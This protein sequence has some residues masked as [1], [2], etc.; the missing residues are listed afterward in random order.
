[1]QT[2]DLKNILWELTEQYGISTLEDQDKI[3]N[4]L[5][6]R[7]LESALEWEL[8]YELG[9]KK[10]QRRESEEEW[11]NKNYRNGSSS[12]KVQ[13][14]SWEI[15]IAIPRDRNS[16]FE[17]KILPKHQTSIADWEQKII[18]MYGLWMSNT[19]IRS[20]FEEIYGVGISES[21]ISYITDKIY[22][23]IE[24][25]KYRP[26]KAVYPIVY[27]DCIHYKVRQDGKII[28][29]ACYS[30]LW[31][32]L[33]GNK[34]IL[35][36]VIWENEG[37]K[38]WLQVINQLKNRGVEDIFIACIDGL[39][40]FPEALTTVYPKTEV[41]LCI[42]HQIRNST[43]HVSYKDIKAF[44]SDLKTVYRAE[45]EEKALKNLELMQEQWRDY[46]HI[47]RSWKNN[48]SEL[49]TMF[50]YPAEIRRLIYTTNTVEGFHRGLRKYTKTKPIF[51]TDKSVEKALYLAMKNV[52]KR[53]T[54][55][56]YWWGKIYGQLALFF[57]ERIQ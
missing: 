50:A 7:M 16:I 48:W 12:K 30:I 56:I 52:T 26:L 41:Q 44:M 55:K 38:F 32:D 3:L 53:W 11:E 42:I 51:P 46:P 47:F 27:L 8:G 29:K 36:L 18:S 14:S 13:T 31:I 54:W 6:K 20:H 37:A 5:K 21:K 1:M 49:A 33:D 35:S 9:Y 43:K 39:K 15:D 22:G 25:W 2:E 23:E 45:T 10:S 40:W 28:S 24:D 19:D 17:P 34:D 57:E 4:A